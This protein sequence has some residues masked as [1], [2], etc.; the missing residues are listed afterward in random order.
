[1][2]PKVDVKTL[3]E[4]KNNAVGILNELMEEFEVI[5]AVKL[6]LERLKAVIKLVE[7]KYGSV[8]KE[9]EAILG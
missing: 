2:Q 5:F 1:M 7:S 9:Q 8:K 3:T 6:R 4:K